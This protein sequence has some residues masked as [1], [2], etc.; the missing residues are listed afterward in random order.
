LEEAI[1]VALEQGSMKKKKGLLLRRELGTDQR[2]ICSKKKACSI[3]EQ[4]LASGGSVEI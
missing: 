4:K 1:T 3:E 2:I